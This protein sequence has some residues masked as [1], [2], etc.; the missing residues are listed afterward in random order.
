MKIICSLI[1]SLLIGCGSGGG[2]GG[3]DA[4]EAQPQCW[5]GIDNDNDGLI[6]YGVDLDCSLPTDNDESGIII[7]PIFNNC[8]EGLAAMDLAGTCRRNPP[9]AGALEVT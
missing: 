2:S 4:S 1:L 3:G 9:T 8:G 5:D 6:D 7:P